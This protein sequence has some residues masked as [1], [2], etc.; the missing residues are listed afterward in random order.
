M[1]NDRLFFQAELGGDALS[2]P[3]KEAALNKSPEDFRVDADILKLK[4]GTIVTVDASGAV[5]PAEPG[6]KA[7]GFLLLD[8]R[9]YDYENIPAYASG[10]VAV[11][12]AVSQCSTNNVL[13][14]NIVP[15]DKLSISAGG[16][17]S[18]A[19][20]AEKDLVGIAL[21]ANSASDKTIRFKAFL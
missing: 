16:V 17:I 4:A 7:I 1:T 11:V 12:C 18:K 9:G 19:G 2:L 14:D 15:G 8:A 13:E 20:N 10:L 3:L 21:T 6:E 5:K